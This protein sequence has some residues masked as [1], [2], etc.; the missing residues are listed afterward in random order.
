MASVD[1]ILDFWFGN[2]I[3]SYSQRKKLWFVK[4]L[5]VDQTL[6]DRFLSTYEQAAAGELDNWQSQPSSC[7]AL[8]IVLDQFPRN[9][10]RGEP[11]AFA[12]DP[13]ARIIAKGAIARGFDQQL[14]PIQRFFFYLPLEHS[15]DLADQHQSIAL[16]QA[17]V[18]DFPELQ[19]G[20][21]YAIR[22]RDVIQ[23]FGRFPH[24]NAI[25]NRPSTPEEIEFLKQPG[26]SF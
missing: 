13:Q 10:F 23:R 26:S 19:D 11:R 21:E 6:R 7:L 1:E 8:I 25:L 9:I 3:E 22:H 4:D 5:S 16:Y 17:L 2:P 18:V 24:R 12:T 20:L 15:E 14:E